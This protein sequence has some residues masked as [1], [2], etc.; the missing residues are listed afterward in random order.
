MSERPYLCPLTGWKSLVVDEELMLFFRE[1]PKLL[2]AGVV[3]ERGLA[4]MIGCV[5]ST[6]DGGEK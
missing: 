5:V 2:Y 6:V 3:G 1:F 4:T